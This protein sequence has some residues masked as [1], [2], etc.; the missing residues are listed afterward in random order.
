[1]HVCKQKCRQKRGKNPKRT[2][3]KE[4]VPEPRKLKTAKICSQHAREPV[5]VMNSE[6]LMMLIPI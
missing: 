1:M 2:Y 4:L 5:P 6:E 3:Y